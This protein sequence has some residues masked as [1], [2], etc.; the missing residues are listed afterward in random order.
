MIRIGLRDAKGHF[1][2]F[3]MS[4]IAIA[5]GVAF[6]VGSFCFREMLNNQ[7]EQM[8]ATTADH[9]VYVR[10]PDRTSTDHGPSPGAPS[11]M[12]DSNQISSVLVTTT[13]TVNGRPSSVTSSSLTP[14]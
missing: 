11:S 3:V 13:T 5:L 6:V 10:G 8:M 14:L 9:A 7:T 4:I 1:R 12:D 2:R